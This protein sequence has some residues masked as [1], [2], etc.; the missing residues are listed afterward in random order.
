[1]AAAA[2]SHNIPYTLSTVATVPLE[3]IPPIAGANAWFQFYPPNDASVERSMLERCLNAGYGTILLTVDVPV[4]V[5]SAAEVA[6]ALAAHPFPIG[7]IE[8]KL[9]HVMFLADPAPADAAA[10][11][12]DHSPD[13][14]AVIGR[15]IHVRYP[16]GQARSTLTN[17]LVDR[18]LGTISTARNLP[19]CRKIAAGLG[20]G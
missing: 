13:E 6:A 18:R 15:E 12:G 17:V 20:V 3:A 16:G 9:H 2:R 1:M 8:P 19:T 4:V 5:R 7:E 10:R 14:Y 11:I